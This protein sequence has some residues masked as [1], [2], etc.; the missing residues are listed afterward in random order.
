MPQRFSPAPGS[1]PGDR[2]K[3]VCE[4]FAGIGLVQEGLRGSG[5]QCLY[6]GDIDP[7]KQA[8]YE[9]HY[10]PSPHYHLGDVWD[11]AEVVERIAR[12]P[13][14][15]TASFPC[16]D[17]SLAG[18]RQGLAGSESSALFGFLRIVE[19]LGP[20][21]PRVILLENVPG[22]LTARQGRDFAAAIEALAGLGYWIDS[23]VIDARW[24]VPQSRPRL[25]V[26]GYHAGLD[27][28]PLV[29][30]PDATQDWGSAWQRAVDRAAKIRPSRLRAVMERLRPSTGWTTVD[31]GSPEQQTYD[32]ADFLDLD[33]TQDWWTDAESDRHL[34]MT[35]DSHRRR[36]ELLRGRQEPLLVTGF[37]RVRQG[38]QRLEVRFDGIA[39]CLRT[40][41]GG[42]AKQLVLAVGRNKV[43]MRWMTPREYARLQGADDFR[44]PANT[45]QGLFGFGDAVCVPAIRWID[46]HMLTPVYESWRAAAAGGVEDPACPIP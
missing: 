26:A 34:E 6:A 9:G 22:F 40:P 25:F 11:A 4:F 14:L 16:T 1:S 10:G 32:L 42:S 24:F 39:G 38:R 3:T 43:R 35:S 2:D 15:A 19:T 27:R 37:R 23:F 18:K 29:R 13:F 44:L 33:A 41:R 31:A 20:R 12:P 5:W 7:K 36:V 17:M 30:R 45:L 28:P 46:R 21:A 8:M